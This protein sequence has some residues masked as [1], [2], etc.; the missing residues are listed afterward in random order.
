MG[1]YFHFFRGGWW[2]DARAHNNFMI[3]KFTAQMRPRA[4]GSQRVTE[5]HN[6]FIGASINARTK[7]F[8][9]RSHW[10]SLQSGSACHKILKIDTRCA[11]FRCKW[12]TSSQGSSRRCLTII[13][14]RTKPSILASLLIT[15]LLAPSNVG[16]VVGCGGTGS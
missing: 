11:I 13:C 15:F 2:N 10:L 4:Q 14:R 16:T 8:L 5:E 3:A 7:E 12:P 1:L 9:E 6:S